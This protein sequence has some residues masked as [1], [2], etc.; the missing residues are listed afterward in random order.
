MY[1]AKYL[2]LLF[3][4]CGYVCTTSEVDEAL[5]L[6]RNKCI[7]R[8]FGDRITIIFSNSCS[9]GGCEHTVAAARV[10]NLKLGAVGLPLP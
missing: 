8:Q 3:Q 9:L 10:K 7:F 6:T 2:D 4:L 1:L 5:N